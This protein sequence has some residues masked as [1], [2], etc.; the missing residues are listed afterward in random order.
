[1]RAALAHQLREVELGLRARADAD[2]DDPAV[3]RERVEVRGEVRR[4]DELEDDVEGPVL[5]EA[6]G[7]DDASAPERGDLRRA[8]PGCGPSR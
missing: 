1:M 2:H 7:L 8:A 4:A 6:L 5:A 3:G